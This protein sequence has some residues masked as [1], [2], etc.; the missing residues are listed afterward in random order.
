MLGRYRVQISEIDFE[1]ESFFISKY[2]DLVRIPSPPAN[3]SL[4]S[5]MASDPEAK[6]ELITRRLQEVL[7]GDIIKA[8]LAEG[9][10]PKCYWGKVNSSSYLCDPLSYKQ[11]IRIR[12]YR[13]PWVLRYRYASPSTR[14]TSFYIAHIGYFV[15]LTKIADFLRAGVE[16]TILLAGAPASYMILGSR[17]TGY[18]SN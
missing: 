4:C 16:V 11:E 2:L 18:C 13:A 6:Y 14:S 7:G 3:R 8:I 9:R 1:S 12:T 10:S 15:P 17:V 5:R